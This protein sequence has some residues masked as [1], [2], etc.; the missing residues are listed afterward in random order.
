MFTSV[1][2]CQRLS[3]RIHVVWLLDPCIPHFL[4]NILNITLRINQNVATYKS[5]PDVIITVYDSLV[6]LVASILPS[7]IKCF[8]N[9]GRSPS[10]PTRQSY[11][12][13]SHYCAVFLS[14]CFSNL[15]HSFHD[16]WSLL[17]TMSSL[18]AGL[19]SHP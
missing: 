5:S 9:L 4:H 8:L 11:L 13:L 2:H 6:P 14:A 1:K 16:V 19:C 10:C 15:C 7:K 18:A 3:S 17:A 12:Q